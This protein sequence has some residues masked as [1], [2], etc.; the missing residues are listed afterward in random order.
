MSAFQLPRAFTPSILGI[1]RSI[2]SEE[3]L[4]AHVEMEATRAIEKFMRSR[5]PNVP[6]S[7]LLRPGTE[8][9][10]FYDTSIQN[11]PKKMD[12]G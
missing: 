3:L 1:P 10:I 6:D 12:R 4:K 9:F 5:I 8:V 2:V 7:R 11:G